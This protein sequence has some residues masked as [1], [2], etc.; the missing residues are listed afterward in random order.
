MLKIEIDM[1]SGRPNPVW[2]ITDSKEADRLISA[3]AESDG[4][5]AKPGTGFN[6]LGFREID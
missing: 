5:T 1:F 6:G 2:Y 4:V 3:I